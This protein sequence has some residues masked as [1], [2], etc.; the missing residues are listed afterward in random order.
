[1]DL[2][3]EVSQL[4]SDEKLSGRFPYALAA[5]LQPYALEKSDAADLVAMKSVIEKEVEHVLS[6]QGAD[7]GGDK[8]GLAS[9][10]G[11]WLEECWATT[12]VEGNVSEPRPQD[13]INL[14][15]VETFMNRMRGEA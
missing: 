6:R 14:F 7:L 15:L 11:T 3:A 4:S 9:K 2:M 1:L 10:I 13:F 12:S 5:L 8:K